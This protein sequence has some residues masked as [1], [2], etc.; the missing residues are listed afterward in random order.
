MRS[1]LLP[2]SLKIKSERLDT[3]A[4]APIDERFRYPAEIA[5][6]ISSESAFSHAAWIKKIR[7]GDREA[8]ATLFRAYHPQLCAFVFRITG[9]EAVAEE[10][11]QEVFTRIWERRLDWDPKGSVDRYLYRAVKNRALNHV[12]HI[13]VE[14][15]SREEIAASI[16]PRQASP[17]ERVRLDELSS[18]TQHA[19]DELPERCRQIFLLS[20]EGNLTYVKIAALLEISPKTVEVQMGRALK[21]LRRALAEYL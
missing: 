1:E 9:S 14:D 19:I 8:F 16:R 17:E 3:R 4:P 20:R 7:S 11:V 15:A 2:P 12:E 18:A 13:R 5:V 6:V 21:S 10:L